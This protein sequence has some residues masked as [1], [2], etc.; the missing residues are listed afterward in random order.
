MVPYFT[1]WRL[2]VFMLRVLGRIFVGGVVVLEEELTR[3]RRVDDRG[4]SGAVAEAFQQP[5]PVGEGAVEGAG[6]LAQLKC[7]GVLPQQP[8]D[9]DLCLNINET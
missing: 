5:V 2:F 3:V 9:Q 7:L 6:G 4:D 1:Q 8:A